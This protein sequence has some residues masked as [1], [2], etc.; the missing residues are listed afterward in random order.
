[1]NRNPHRESYFTTLA[2]DGVSKRKKGMVVGLTVVKVSESPLRP[3]DEECAYENVSQ[4]GQRAHPPHNGVTNEI[5][6]P[7]VFDPKVLQ[8]GG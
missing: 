5:N 8:V 3:K 7:M 2:A 4:D 1:M 6:L